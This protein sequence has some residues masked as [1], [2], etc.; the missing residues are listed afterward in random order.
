MTGADLAERS[1][2]AAGP[3][4]TERPTKRRAE[5]PDTTTVTRHQH[6]AVV[7][8]ED[9]VY[10][11][12]VPNR[13]IGISKDPVRIRKRPLQHPAPP[14]HDPRPTTLP[15]PSREVNEHARVK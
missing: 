9:I 1:E 3:V 6:R 7:Q 8:V 15:N 2:I 4:Q 5:L 10:M 12:S 13:T 11:A 14:P